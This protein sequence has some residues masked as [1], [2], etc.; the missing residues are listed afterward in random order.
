MS[1]ARVQF[2]KLDFYDAQS[3]EEEIA[4]PGQEV[5]F[6]FACPKHV[7]RRCEALLIAGRPNIPR[8]GQNKNGGKAQWDWNG[9]REAPTFVPS[10]DC[11]GCWHG[12]IENGRCVSTSKQDEPEPSA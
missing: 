4:A 3:E 9:N 7:R 1:D 5:Y 2:L 12:Y 10:V 8:D 11:S 6:G